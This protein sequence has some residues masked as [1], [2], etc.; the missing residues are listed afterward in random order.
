MISF[1]DINKPDFF[2]CKHCHVQ[3][4]KASAKPDE[5]LKAAARNYHAAK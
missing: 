3:G 4:G 1:D 5:Q 2:A